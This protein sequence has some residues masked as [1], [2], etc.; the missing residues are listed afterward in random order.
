MIS[1][2]D[3]LKEEEE[4]DFDLLKEEEEEIEQPHIFDNP[5]NVLSL[6]D[7]MS[8]GQLALSRAGIKVSNYFASEI[9]K[10]A[11]KVTQHNFPN[12]IQL[13]DVTKVSSQDLPKIDLLIGGSP[14]Q[15]FS[16]LG[17][18]RNFED[19][20]S[21]LFF[22]YV[23]LLEEVKPKYFLLENVKMKKEWRDLI[24][25]HLGVEPVLLDSVKVSAQQR[26][27]YFWANFPISEPEDKGIHISSILEEKEKDGKPWIP[28]RARGFYIDEEGKPYKE[29]PSGF[30]GKTTQC[31][32][33]AKK[34]DKSYC[35]TTTEKDTILTTLSEGIYV[36]YK[37]KGLP[38]RHY[39][40][41]ERLRLMSF[42]DNYCEVVSKTQI[43]EMT[44]NGWE[45]NIITHIFNCMKDFDFEQSTR[46]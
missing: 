23:R 26:P 45:T 41:I 30:I 5:I 2:F 9:D 25:H 6:F 7:G 4:I 18:D 28:A 19:P 35:L 40:P 21:R 1:I 20:Q 3:V 29:K 44:G 36:D 32:I 22:E 38:W 27:R 34:L 14:C 15:G 12:T 37:N 33:T 13:G 17:L 43:I 42:P 16:A 10:H 8:C 39:T 31:L 11:I 24:S 46:K